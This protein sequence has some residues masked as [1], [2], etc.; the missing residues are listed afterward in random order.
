MVIT[1]YADLIFLWNFILDFFLLFLIHPEDKIH[2]CRLAAAAAIGAGAVLLMLYFSLDTLLLFFLL[3]FFVAG[4]M[5][6]VA[7]PARGIGEFFC[8]TALL[9]GISSCLYG[10]SR[11]VSEQMKVLEGRS[12]WIVMFSMGVLLSGKM[13]YSFRK[14]QYRRL[15]YHFRIRMKNGVRQVDKRAFYDS[16]NHLIE[17]ISGK[18]VILV[19]R[20]VVAQL[21]ISAEKLR[22]VPYSS[23][24]KASGMLEAYP[25]EELSVC[26]G[27]GESKYKHIYMAV[28]EDVMFAQEECD[29]ILHAD[30]ST[31][32]SRNKSKQKGTKQCY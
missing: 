17:P 2:Y 31:G 13:L 16:G 4:V 12:V 5:V 26:D 15:V 7:I 18:P 22:I 19:R 10:V 29:V 20:S 28:A 25:L 24:G 14:R 23:L 30:M 1:Y 3:R 11:L 32:D 27:K 9:Y 8:N 21:D 6:K